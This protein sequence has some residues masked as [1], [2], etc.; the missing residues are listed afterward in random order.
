MNVLNVC[1]S[2]NTWNYKWWHSPFSTSNI[3]NRTRINLGA[4]KFWENHVCCHVLI[5]HWPSNGNCNWCPIVHPL[6]EAILAVSR[7][8]FESFKFYRNIQFKSEPIP[9][10]KKP[11]NVQINL[12]KKGNCNV[13]L[14]VHCKVIY[15]FARNFKGN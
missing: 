6:H 3:D 5:C 1:P 10:L 14:A 12:L 9:K 7:Q 15:R 13:F 4:A 11:K 8:C 2:V